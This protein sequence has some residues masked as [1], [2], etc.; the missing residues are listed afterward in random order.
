MTLTN[1]QVRELRRPYHV[2]AVKFLPIGKVTSG[3]QMLPHL[4]ASLVIERL[5]DVDPGWSEDTK[6]VLLGNNADDPMGLVHQSPWR[7]ELTVGGV[8]RV[9]YGQLD[10]MSA[11]LDGKHIKQ[12]ESDALKRAALKFGVGAYL[13]AI[14]TTWLSKQVGGADAFKVNQSGKFNGLTP[15]GKK[16]LRDAY[17]KIVTHSAFVEHYGAM[18]DYG[19]MADEAEDHAVLAE[20]GNASDA[21]MEV[22]VI[23]SQYTGRDTSEDYVRTT[24]EGKPF[25]KTLAALLTAVRAHLAVSAEDVERLRGLAQAAAGGSVEAL[26]EMGE[27]LVQLK[28]QAEAGEPDP[29]GQVALV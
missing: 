25:T 21:E 3:V 19:D 13:R 7:C 8:T 18:I 2:N 5:S 10:A 12:G 26:A 27:G 9:G 11:R 24:Y 17:M 14:P 16:H 28:A 6:P 15:A 29:D 20:Q 1:D 23:L 22:L 4:D